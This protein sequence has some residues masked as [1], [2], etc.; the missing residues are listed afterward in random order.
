MYW[1][2]SQYLQFDNSQIQYLNETLEN[3]ATNG[4]LNLIFPIPNGN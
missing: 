2:E 3:V 1:L 4:T